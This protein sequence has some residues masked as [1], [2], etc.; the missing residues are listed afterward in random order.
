MD[1]GSIDTSP[2][3]KVGEFFSLSALAVI[4]TLGIFFHLRIP[5]ARPGKT[6]DEYAP[7]VQGERAGAV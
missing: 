2:P 7:L 1:L 3:E 6:V 4:M 5:D